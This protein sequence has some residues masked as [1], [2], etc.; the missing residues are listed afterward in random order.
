MRI[1]PEMEINT[2][3]WLSKVNVGAKDIRVKEILFWGFNNFIKSFQIHTGSNP[4][5]THSA[6]EEISIFHKN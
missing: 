4:F 1:I 3:E 6:S 5:C 2:K